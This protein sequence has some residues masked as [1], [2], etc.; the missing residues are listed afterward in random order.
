MTF[1]RQLRTVPLALA[2][3]TVLL[4]CHRS[5]EQH[6]LDY[7]VAF[8]DMVDG[9]AGDGGARASF[10]R[11]GSAASSSAANGSSPALTYPVID[12]SVSVAYGAEGNEE[13]HVDGER[14][15]SSSTSTTIAVYDEPGAAP[16]SA[17]DESQRFT[18][19][20]AT[21]TQSGSAD[22]TVVAH[23]GD[24]ATDAEHEDCDQGVANDG[25]YGGCTSDCHLASRCGDGVVD[26]EY[27]EACDDGDETEVNGCTRNCVR[28]S[29]L[30]V[31]YKFD[32]GNGSSVGDELG[33]HDARVAYG[34]RW[35]EAPN[36]EGAFKTNSLEVSG[37]YAHLERVQ[38]LLD[39]TDSA[40]T[41]PSTYVDMGTLK[42]D[43]TA[44]TISVWAR[45]VNRDENAALLVWLGSNGD[46]YGGVHASNGLW[47]PN[48]EVWIRHESKDG[49]TGKFA[50]TMGFAASYVFD[51]YEDEVPEPI[52]PPSTTKC[53]LTAY[54]TYQ[55]WHHY[56]ITL[57]NLQNPD[58]P[59]AVRAVSSF[60]GYVDGES[61]G[62]TDGCYSVNLNRFAGALLGRPGTRTNNASWMGDIDD[63]MMFDV[64]L[65]AAEVNELY[66]SQKR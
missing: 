53:A 44:A 33:S 15:S 29:G 18:N 4:S 6:E 5:N 30:K 3:S 11:D 17:G 46:G 7:V 16:T 39:P 42:P 27:G 31:W 21:H 60:A 1:G 34:R 55:S 45:R 24:G 63:F 58:D 25:S 57:N 47:S 40:T 37:G 54:V 10:V 36:Y 51:I 62:G 22:G 48:H 38:G 49:D 59:G 19:S 26:D 23:C 52:Q 14:G 32:E 61:I 66:L 64:I 12:S 43:G 65:E 50:L 56:V 35:T 41:N 8:D 20:A 28:S 9:G 2:S 13:P